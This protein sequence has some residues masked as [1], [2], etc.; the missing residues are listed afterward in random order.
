[1]SSDGLPSGHADLDRGH[2]SL[3]ENLLERVLVVEVLS[4]PF[5]P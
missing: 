4:T 2:P 5:D 3:S 1:M